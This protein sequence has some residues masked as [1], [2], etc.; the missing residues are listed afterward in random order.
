MSTTK[1]GRDRQIAR[2]PGR[3]AVPLW[4]GDIFTALGCSLDVKIRGLWG[5]NAAEPSNLFS[6]CQHHGPPRL[7]NP[8]RGPRRHRASVVRVL[9]LCGCGPST[10]RPHCTPPRGIRLRRQVQRLDFCRWPGHSSWSGERLLIELSPPLQE[11]VPP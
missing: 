10:W 9:T 7:S 8:L 5:G 4:G 2:N 1:I 3:P 11:Q 6:H